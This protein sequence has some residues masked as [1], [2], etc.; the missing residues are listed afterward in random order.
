MIGQTPETHRSRNTTIR[1]NSGF[2]LNCKEDKTKK[3]KQQNTELR[4]LPELPQKYG[5]C[6]N[7]MSEKCWKFLKNGSYLKN[8]NDEYTI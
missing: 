1:K 6:Q 4:I 7:K 8:N 5:K 3:T 2:C